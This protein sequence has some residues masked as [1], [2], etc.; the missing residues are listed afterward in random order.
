MFDLFT[1]HARFAVAP[2]GPLLFALIRLRKNRSILACRRRYARTRGAIIARLRRNRALSTR[3]RPRRARGGTWIFDD[4][5]C[6]R[7]LKLCSTLS[8]SAREGTIINLAGSARARARD[9]HT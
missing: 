4:R 5:D 6:R 3:V 1:R 2:G 8:K 9:T 7:D